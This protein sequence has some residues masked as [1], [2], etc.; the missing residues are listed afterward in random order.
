LFR[1]DFASQLCGKTSA[2]HLHPHNA[3]RSIFDIK[4]Q[5]EQ[6]NKT[7]LLFPLFA[8]GLIKISMHPTNNY[9]VMSSYVDVSNDQQQQQQQHY[10]NNAHADASFFNARN[11]YPIG[12]SSF[13]DLFTAPIGIEWDLQ[14]L[15]LPPAV[16]V[17][18]NS[19]PVATS[20]ATG[21]YQSQSQ[22][23]HQNRASSV[24][25]HNS[26]N[27]TD[28]DSSLEENASVCTASTDIFDDEQ[29][30]V[31]A[32]PYPCNSSSNGAVMMMGMYQDQT[33]ERDAGNLELTF[34][35]EPAQNQLDDEHRFKPF[36]EE[37]WS[38][39]YKELILFHGEYG[40]SA[41]P[42]TFPP[43]QQLAR[44]VKRYV[45]FLLHT[46]SFFSLISLS[47]YPY[48]HPRHLLCIII[49]ITV[50]DGNSSCCKK[51]NRRRS[52]RNGWRC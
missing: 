43:N 35:E 37:K 40:H 4:I 41:V 11:F 46:M 8:A 13:E 30:F 9:Q 27:G 29:P 36:H 24:I 49:F 6:T 31:V 25:S 52:R 33:M 50:N 1:F 48:S 17:P 26:G 7:S 2:L 22:Y 20:S 23:Y 45:Y 34:N 16:V 12:D 39:R 3:Q 21:V 28:A 32:Q 15:A 47:T 42:H 38:V 51:T 14:P 10:H 19:S 18:Q 5:I 44:W